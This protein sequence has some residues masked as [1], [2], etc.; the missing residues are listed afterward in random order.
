MKK[1]LPFLTLIF[2][3]GLIGFSTYNLNNKETLEASQSRDS[4]PEDVGVHFQ[5]T[6]ISLPEFSLPDLFE[7]SGEFS[8]KDLI[9]KFSV[10]NFF[11]SWCTTCRAE[12]EI[13]LRLKSENIV[14]IYGVAWHDIDENTKNYLAKSGNPYT[15]VAKDARGLFT[16][17]TGMQAV[18][19]TLI[20][21]A[22]GNV[23]RRFRGNLQE[24]SLEEIRQ[25]L[26]R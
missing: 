19:E 18:P 26:K 11:A 9:G 16:K 3:L 7:E 10:I 6:H 20:I 24:F 5:K 13:L 15:K 4:N 14:D 2:L 8:K 21:D 12:H 25:F 22:K 23:V 17:I 1:F